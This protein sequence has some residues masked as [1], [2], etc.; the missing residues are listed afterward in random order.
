MAF[1]KKVKEKAETY[2][3]RTKKTVFLLALWGIVFSVA[4]IAKLEVGFGYDT[5]LVCSTAAYRKAMDQGVAPYSYSFWSIVNRSYD[6]EH[7]KIIPMAIAWAFRIFGFKISI[8]TS[9]PD[10]DASGLRK[11]WRLLVNPKRFIF[12]QSDTAKVQYL[13]SG[14]FILFFGGADSE[15]QAARAARVYP[16]RILQSKECLINPA[17]YHPGEFHEH[18]VPFSQY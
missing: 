16:I 12:A 13:D 3:S 11:D 6:L 18:K 14:N 7:P 1:H 17:D 4:T 2:W 10:I 9:R 8:I 15:I 5:T